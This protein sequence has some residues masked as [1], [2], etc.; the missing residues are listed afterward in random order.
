LRTDDA[1]T[2]SRRE[3]ERA[4]RKF[5][6]TYSDLMR[7]RFQSWGGVFTQ[8]M[9][10]CETDPVMRVVTDPLR[11]NKNVDAE[12]WHADTLGTVRGMLGSGHFALPPDDDDRTALLYQFFLN[13][14]AGKADVRTFCIRVYGETKYQGMVQIFND[15]FVLKFARE[16]TYRLDDVMK[17][18]GNAEVIASEQMTVFHYHDHSTHNNAMNFH[19]PVQGSNVA[20]PGASIADSTAAYNTNAD[21][22]EALKALR[23]LISD[24]VEG[25]KDA[26]EKALAVL[27]E[28]THKDVPVAQVAQ[29]TETVAKASPTLG[30]RLRDISGKIGLSLVASA[31]VQGIKMGLGIH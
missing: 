15:E 30:E 12:K 14:E 26:V 18:V 31:L 6:D 11:K 8:L 23:P 29:A 21:L 20:G 4:F 17:D 19:G 9:T 1:E 3:V 27:V 25:Q 16:V 22:A 24:V 13:I 2:F 10:H 7:A 5:K 28:A